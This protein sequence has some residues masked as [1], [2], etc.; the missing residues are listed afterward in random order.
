MIEPRCCPFCGKKPKVGPANPEVEG[1]AWAFVRCTNRRC[2]ARPMVKDGALSSD[3]RG[4]DKYK[5]LAIRR[6]NRRY[7]DD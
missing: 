4:S 7:F 3:E 1:N 2:P 6:W 5:E